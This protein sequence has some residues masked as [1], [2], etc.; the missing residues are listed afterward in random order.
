MFLIAVLGLSA[1][2]YAASL[3]VT[4]V[5][6]NSYQLVASERVDESYYQDTYRVTV[7]NRGSAFVANAQAKLRIRGA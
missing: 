3:V 6:V 4:D 7:T 5:V 1:A 2:G